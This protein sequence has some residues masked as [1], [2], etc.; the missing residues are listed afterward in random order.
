MLIKERRGRKNDQ[1]RRE[2]ERRAL[3]VYVISPFCVQLITEQ[4]QTAQEQQTARVFIAASVKAA[5]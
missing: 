1:E 2:R 3:T 4:T 5:V